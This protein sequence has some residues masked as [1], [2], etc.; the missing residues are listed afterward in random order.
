M[1]Q[2]VD[3]LKRIDLVQFLSQHYGLEFR[4]R[5]AAFACCSPFTE[6]SSASF[7]VR[8][9]NGHWV[10][11]DFSGGAAGTIFDFV[12]IKEKLASF[13]EVLA[14]IRGLLGSLP[15]CRAR[16]SEGGDG[17]AADA[18][19]GTPAADRS[20]NVEALYE[21]FRREDPEV[22]RQYLLSRGI[23][24]DLTEGLIANGT[25]VHNRH[26]GH[27]YCTFAVRDDQGQLK[28]LDNHA[29]EGEGKFVLGAKSPFSLDWEELKHA[30][31]VFLAEGVIDYLSVKTLESTPP[32]GLALLGNQLCF[33]AALLERAEVLLS[34][35]DDDRGGDSAVLDLKITYPE[36]EVRIYDLEGY[37]D[38]NEL[39]VAARTGKGR[40]LSPERK[41]QLYRE[42]QQSENK[43]ELAARW[44]IDRSH[45]YEIVRDCEAALVGALA[46]RKL[47]RPPKGKPATLAE[48]LERIEQ[49]EEQ[50]E[51]EATRREELYC[52]SELLALRLKWAEIDAA[53]ARG[54]KVEE[55]KGPEKE[56][57][58]K[59]K[60]NRR[61]F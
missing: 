44:G 17:R 5:G 43:A 39:L 33:D 11:K 51:Q 9:V 7:F 61:R 34:A 53:E 4:R 26:G 10:F 27:S 22:C 59:K 28:C 49:L 14:F 24:A 35:M 46:S 45:L 3:A 58:I 1:I 20:Y 30:K 31:I 16:Q 6:E 57:Q 15:L 13:S 25:V 60:K 18:S 56:A 38:P 29:I 21:R 23:A 2:D 55:A 8:L 40:R 37:K 36:K 47:G 12:R 54:E 52:R 42:F 50:Y 41:L 19:G 32:P 48:A